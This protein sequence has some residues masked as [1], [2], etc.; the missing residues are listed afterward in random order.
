MTACEYL[1]WERGQEGRH[2]FDGGEIFA[3]AG[4]TRGTTPSVRP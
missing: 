3:M 4:G 2:E 1:A